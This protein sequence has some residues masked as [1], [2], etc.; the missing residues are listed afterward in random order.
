MLTFKRGEDTI[1][2]TL[3]AEGNEIELAEGSDVIASGAVI[4][5]A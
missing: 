4:I 3:K 1:T 2:L 5:G